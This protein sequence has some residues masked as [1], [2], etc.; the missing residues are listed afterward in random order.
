M[1]E[2]WPKC[3]EFSLSM[4]NFVQERHRSLG[5]SP[6]RPLIVP[7]GGSAHAKFRSKGIL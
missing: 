3:E 7:D 6:F 1:A 5:W 4:K 2:L